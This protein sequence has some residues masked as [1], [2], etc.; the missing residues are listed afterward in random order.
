MLAGSNL[1]PQPF[2]TLM[3]L[4]PP[5]LPDEESLTDERRLLYRQREL[6]ERGLRILDHQLQAVHAK[7]LAPAIRNAWAQWLAVYGQL[8]RLTVDL[9]NAHAK[10][11]ELCGHKIPQPLPLG[12]YLPE[13]ADRVAQKVARD[14][15][16]QDVALDGLLRRVA[17]CA[18]VGT[19]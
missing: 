3:C 7:T 17:T 13:E 1:K 12:R 16:V 14:M 19:D 5:S 6:L 4:P 15:G 2:L 11:R 9:D 8:V 18:R 10:A